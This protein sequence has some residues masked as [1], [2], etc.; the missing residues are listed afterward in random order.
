MLISPSEMS[1]YENPGALRGDD[2]TA[3]ISLQGM[4]LMSEHKT[5][6]EHGHEISNTPVFMIAV[7]RPVLVVR[8]VEVCLIS[9]GGHKGEE[10]GRKSE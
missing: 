9:E 6:S 8:E 1:R 4:I 5:P 7:H 3:G 10:K 2:H